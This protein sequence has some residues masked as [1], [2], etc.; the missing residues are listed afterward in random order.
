MTRTST[1]CG[2]SVTTGALFYYAADGVT[3]VSGKK[4]HGGG[5]HGAPR[6]HAPLM[7]GKVGEIRAFVMHPD[8]KLSLAKAAEEA[9]KKMAEPDMFDAGI[10]A[11]SQEGRF[12]QQ[13]KRIEKRHEEELE[14]L[15][16]EMANLEADIEAGIEA[17]TAEVPANVK[18]MLEKE[19]ERARN[20]LPF[21]RNQAKYSAWLEENKQNYIHQAFEGWNDSD[22]VFVCTKVDADGKAKL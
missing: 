6:D 1:F 2:L 12:F 4:G 20:L 5:H 8:S 19:L 15:E 16:T 18:P 11:Y 21:Y 22:P 13:W 7:N 17:G 10:T 3:T 9:E 14:K